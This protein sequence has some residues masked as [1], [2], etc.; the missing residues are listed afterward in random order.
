MS[1]DTLQ[2]LPILIVSGTDF[3]FRI[4]ARI[5]REEQLGRSFTPLVTSASPAEARAAL[6]AERPE[7]LIID[8]GLHTAARDYVWLRSFLGQ[9]RERYGK[10]V[11]T[12]L[13]ITT[14]EKLAFGGLLLLTEDLSGQ[15][16]GL[17]DNL[18]IAPPSGVPSIATLEGQ[19][20]DCLGY[21]AEELERR[22][23]GKPALPSLW[24]S[25]WVPVMCDPESRNVWMRWLPRYAVYINENPLI[26]GPTGAG[27]T[28]L[29]EAIHRLS[30][31][32]GPFVSITPRDF[33]ST[34]LVQ[35]ELFGAVAGA[36][37]G[38]VE[39]W[40]LVKKAERGTLFIDEL[41][42]ID[43]DLQG[44]LITFIENKTYRRVGEADSHQADVRFV[45]ATNRSLQ[46]LVQD[47][48]LRDDFA[49]RL[50]RLQ[51]ALTPL[52]NRRLDISAG[53]SFAL[54]K[55]L[56]ERSR[57]RGKQQTLNTI[58]IE[59]LTEGA[60]RVLFS[61]AWP[62][63]LRQLENT[64]AKLIELADI[65]NL[66]LIDQECT[67]GT[68][69]GLLGRTE[70]SSADVFERAAIDIALQSNTEGFTGLSECTLALAD[71]A[72]TRALE[73]TGG[74]MAKAAR[75]IQDSEKAMNLFAATS[76]AYDGLEQ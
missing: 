73:L 18:I 7:I 36:Y 12:I 61:S 9:V 23:E 45:F 27:K 48:S 21:A 41:Q 57:I 17:I 54:A 6:V 68:M 25:G 43:R 76:L 70:A 11:Y 16:S 67:G 29:A 44:K 38:A 56:Q 10:G 71:S 22:A 72:R 24:E 1:K 55:V 42:S 31:R 19:L 74:D 65:K 34:E 14:P 3:A 46:D 8:I 63:N 49:Y 33:S 53:I 32:E 40:G 30:G 2:T 35:A 13:A 75:L 5:R 26:V 64:V 66:R 51:I 60:Y 69:K 52:H 28:R 20:I 4:A 37:T 50:E 15:P 47:G 62:G 59:G 39:K 58:P